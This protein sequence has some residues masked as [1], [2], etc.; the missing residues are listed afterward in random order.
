MVDLES[1]RLT[2]EQLAEREARH[3]RRR[4]RIAEI[5]ARVKPSR[6][7]QSPSRADLH[8]LLDACL[9]LAEMREP[10][11]WPA[12]LWSR[13]D[14]AV[15]AARPIGRALARG[16]FGWTEPETPRAVRHVSGA[17]AWFELEHAAV[18]W[19][20][21]MAGRLERSPHVLPAR[22]VRA[23]ADALRRLSDGSGDTPWP[24]A[25]HREPGRGSNPQ[26]ARRMEEEAW[27]W[28]FRRKGAGERIGV[29]TS[30]VADAVGRTPD[31]VKKWR[32][33]WEKRDG[34]ESVK[35]MLEEQ[36]EIGA[37]AEPQPETL[38]DLPGIARRWQAAV[39]PRRAEEG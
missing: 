10:E 9:D 30:K 32:E 33:E 8:A 27:C 15:K 37:S 11:K 24:L 18:Q 25:P 36:K 5:A 34:K 4:E 12:A 7:T 22:M 13:D 28:I 29:A 1:L 19:R 17:M 26:E 21:E 16:A 2:P 6:K 14:D 3:R 31:A 23:L 20:E 38:L 39:D 35:R